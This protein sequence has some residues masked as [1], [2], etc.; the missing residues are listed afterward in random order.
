MFLKG[1][2]GK[3]PGGISVGNNSVMVE[4]ALVLV[5]GTV[6]ADTLVKE[7][8]TTERVANFIVEYI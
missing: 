1:K 5:G 6:S 3:I 2:C 7:I 8:A 4:N